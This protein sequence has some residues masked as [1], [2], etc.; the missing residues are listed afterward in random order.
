[1]KKLTYAELAESD[2]ILTIPHGLALPKAVWAELEPYIGRETPK[3]TTYRIP[4]YL[5]RQL[6]YIAR[7]AKE[8]EA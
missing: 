8:G 4:A 6:E 1:M 5:G 2:I 3:D 7:L